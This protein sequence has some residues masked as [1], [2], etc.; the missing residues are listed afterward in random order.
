M[1]IMLSSGISPLTTH[2]SPPHQTT[3]PLTELKTCG[4]YY[5][6]LY[7][8]ID[9]VLAPCILPVDLKMEDAMIQKENETPS[10]V[11]ANDVASEGET[12]KGKEQKENTSSAVTTVLPSSSESA[13][14]PE[15]ALAPEPEPASA[16]VDTEP[17][18]YWDIHL[19]PEHMLTERHP[20]LAPLPDRRPPEDGQ[21]K[22]PKQKQK[23]N[24]HK[25]N[26]KDSFKR[27]RECTLSDM[28][29]CKQLM[30]GKPCTFG[31]KCKYSHDLKE[32]LA[33]REDDIKEVE[34]GCP[35]FRLY[36]ECPFGLSCR[37]GSCHLNLA[38]GENITMKSEKKYDDSVKN[39]VSYGIM[40]ELRKNKYKFVCQRYQK[41]QK[42]KKRN[43]RNEEKEAEAKAQEAAGTKEEDNAVNVPVPVPVPVPNS[44]DGDNDGTKK[45]EEP[46]K[47]DL[48]PLPKLRKIIDFRNKV[49][50]APLTTVGNLPFRRIM[51]KY[52]ADITCGEMAVA[53]NLLQGRNGEW[54][55]LKRHKDEDIFGVQIASA[56]GDMYERIS[57][58]IKN[59]ELDI[60]FLDMNLGC[61]IDVICKTGAGAKLMQR[62]RSLRDALEGMSKNLSIPIT[63]KIRTGWDEKKPFAHKLVPKIQRWGMGSVG[64]VMLHGR[65]RLQR[66]SK[67]ADWDYIQTV[68]DSQSSEIEKLP[69]IGNGDIFSYVD[70]EE[71]VLGHPSLSPTAMIGRGALI[72][73]W[74]PTEIKERRHWDISATERLDMLKD[75]VKFGLEH[76]GS[77]THGVNSTRRFLLEWLSFLCRYIPVG[78]LE[79]RSIPQSMNQRP[80]KFI[81]GR[82]DLET[83]MMSD[84][85]ADWI[86][87]SEMLLGK[88]REGFDFEPKHKAK[89]YK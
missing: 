54:A 67:L 87:I 78:L 63:V 8:T 3:T 52:G 32:M 26:V 41:G 10:V 35:R 13:P 55:L 89:S 68:A 1:I 61:P 80:P 29:V 62:D 81:C 75:F 72:K 77:D 45:E 34:G 70:Y 59:E 28:K 40:T 31:D 66:Y 6:S 84:N 64:C 18:I 23:K 21:K 22:E 76:W 71:K 58:V 19:K 50:V 42:N 60:D 12:S 2:H 5:F 86:K 37:V 7:F 9:R 27:G 85:Y 44:T 51:K 48:S 24:R 38:T 47:V 83:L 43:D 49:Y 17:K 53:Q 33:L 11:P 69:I 65:S 56:H 14:A 16:P 74:L 4:R 57:E 82:S 88:V 73:P 25:K 20:C 39:I 79:A 36:G 15:S 30:I 46:M